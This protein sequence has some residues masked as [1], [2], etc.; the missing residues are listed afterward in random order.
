MLRKKD[1]ERRFEKR[2]AW[3]A[4]DAVGI[5]W[6]ALAPCEGAKPVAGSCCFLSL[7]GGDYVTP[8]RVIYHT[9]KGYILA[10][11]VCAGGSL[12]G[13]HCTCSNHDPVEYTE[14]NGVEGWIDE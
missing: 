14:L 7:A 11:V 3:D 9:S 4:P 10:S 5:D 6:S 8:S 13:G 2:P 12:F 1:V